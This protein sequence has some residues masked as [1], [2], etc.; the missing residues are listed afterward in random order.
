MK[1]DERNQLEYFA[2]VHPMKNGKYALSFPDFVDVGAVVEQE[3]QVE[4]IAIKLLM[5]KLNKLTL[6]PNPKTK[7]ELMEKL[8][9]GDFLIP[10]CASLEE[11]IS[12]ESPKESLDQEPVKDEK[13]E[14]IEKSNTQAEKENVV[15]KEEKLIQEIEETEK[16]KAEIKFKQEEKEELQKEHTTRENKKENE[17]KEAYSEKQRR[18]MA[19]RAKLEADGVVAPKENWKYTKPM[20][21]EADSSSAEPHVQDQKVDFSKATSKILE[22]GAKATESIKKKVTENTAKMSTEEKSYLL[23]IVS[24]FLYLIGAFLPIISVEAFFE[25]ARIYFF[26]AL[27]AKSGI[28]YEIPD[29]RWTIFG[30]RTLGFLILFAGIFAVVSHVKKHSFYRVSAAGICSVLFLLSFLVLLIKISSF[31]MFSSMISFSWAWI[32]LS[33]GAG[34]QIASVWKDLK[35]LLEKKGEE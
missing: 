1:T 26:S 14:V 23:G 24:S 9:E 21:A 28:L 18:A 5:K 16:Q 19:L 15:P 35:K 13:K 22:E 2:I 32:F 10:V 27:F 17:S 33:L 31:G 8:Q 34:G 29:I 4:G 25:K 12:P 30:V 3:N 7:E 11:E 6:F 20:Q